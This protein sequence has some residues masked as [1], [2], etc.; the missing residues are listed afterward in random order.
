MKN[1]LVTGGA[2]FIG[3]AFVRRMVQKHPDF[4]IIVFDKMTYA[5]NMDNLLLVSKAGNFEFV[6]GDI[7]DREAIRSAFESYG[8]DT[9]VNFAAETH[10]DRSILAPDAFIYSNVVG[11]HILLESAHQHGIERFLHVS[12]DE[13]YGDIEGDHLSLEDDAFKPNSPYAASKAGGDL[14]V[15]AYHVTHGMNTIVTRGSNTFGLYQYPEKLMPF[16]ITEAMDDRPLPVYGDG[17]QVRDWLHVDDHAGGI[18]TA[19]LK[20]KAGEAYNI[21][22]EN[23][24]TNIEVIQ[25]MLK[26]LNKPESLIKYVPDREGHDRRYGMRCDKLRALGW[27]REYNDFDAA[28]ENT[29]RWFRENE[30]WW[31]KIKTGEY[32]EYYKQQYAARLAAAGTTP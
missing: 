32:L 30:W 21:A 20:G 6:Q 3:S 24:K 15:R 1:I 10:V 25:L 23:Q 18:E 29:V 19:L 12:T 14:M 9:V 17:K 31:R 5:G 2:G 16:F 7:A 4:R 11:V 8:V 13:V 28:V 26:H 27:E 22:G